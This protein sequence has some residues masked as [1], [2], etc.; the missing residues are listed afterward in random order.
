MDKWYK[1]IRI[2]IPTPKILKRT[3]KNGANRCPACKKVTPVELLAEEFDVCSCGFHFKIG[4]FEY[5]NILF[6]EGK[7]TEMF[8]NIF[9]KDLLDFK[10]V[11]SYKDRLIETHERTELSES[12]NFAI[13]EING[14]PVILGVMDFPFIGGSIGSVAGEKIARTADHCIANK[15]P[16]ILIS[17]SGGARLME[18]GFSL[19]Q[20]V[21][22]SIKIDELAARGIPY[23]SVMTDPT[24]GSAAAL[25]LTGD[26][27]IAEPNAFIGYAGPKVVM[28]TM[29]KDLPDGFQR[30]EFLLEHGFVDMIVHRKDLKNCLSKILS[31]CW[32]N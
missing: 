26:V 20:M 16:L 9:P 31:L 22:I 3:D 2:G 24:T 12:L 19:M 10:D 28:E 21:K 4:S 23:I 7:F 15:L 1:R 17:R 25:A 11:I 5:Y 29:G 30:S 13:G 27:N 6:D 14:I 18:A 8:T 32:T